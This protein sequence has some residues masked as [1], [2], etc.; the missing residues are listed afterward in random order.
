MNNRI[1]FV[2]S[3]GLLQI[4]GKVLFKIE[5]Q[6]FSWVPEDIHAFHWYGDQID[7]GEIEFKQE[8]P[9]AQKKPNEMI[10]ELGIWSQLIT[11]FEEETQRREESEQLRLEA[12]EASRDYWV[13]FRFLR[14][15][16]LEKSDWTQLNDCALSEEKKIEWVIY[17]QELRNLPSSVTEPKPMVLSY[18]EGTVHAGWPIPPT[19]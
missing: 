11:L 17:R 12:I 16:L 19:E 15:Y 9:L 1:C 7:A 2:P 14:N 18:H 6:Y 5:S 3:D 8:H 13:E 10:T 4:D